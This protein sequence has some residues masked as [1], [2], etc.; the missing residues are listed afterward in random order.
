[1]SLILDALR[2]ADAERESDP[3]R[4]IHA[5]P[6]PLPGDDGDYGATPDGWIVAR[7]L[8]PWAAAGV[9]LLA[10]LVGWRELRPRADVWMPAE[11]SA[12][13]TRSATL[14][15]PASQI[16]PP[17]PPPIASPALVAPVPASVPTASVPRVAARPQAAATPGW[18]E[19]APRLAIAGGVYSSDPVQRMLIINGDV[20]S[21]G[22]EP[23]SGVRIEQILPRTAILGFRGQRYEVDY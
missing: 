19:H 22:T 12:A 14:L 6:L 3:R 21:E 8:L 17:A 11:P 4:G 2:R 7:R 18:P 20:H 15:A 5:Q 1:M 10:A 16:Q 13:A 23:V 9:V